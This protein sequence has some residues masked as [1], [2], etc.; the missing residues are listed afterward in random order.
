MGRISV[1]KTEDSR[2]N[3]LGLAKRKWNKY[4]GKDGEDIGKSKCTIFRL[5]Q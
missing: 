3:R 4:I 1:S 5:S 2:S